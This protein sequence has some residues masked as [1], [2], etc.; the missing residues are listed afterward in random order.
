MTSVTIISS[1]GEGMPPRRSPRFKKPEEGEVQV[2]M[3]AV[4]GEPSRKRAHSPDFSFKESKKVEEVFLRKMP[5]RQRMLPARYREEEKQTPASAKK[6]V[7]KRLLPC[8]LPRGVNYTPFST[9][10]PDFRKE[11]A[12]FWAK[13]GPKI[14]PKR[15]DTQERKIQLSLSRIIRDGDDSYF[16]SKVRVNKINEKVGY[17]VIARDRINAGTVVG[18]YGGEL[19]RFDDADEAD[20]NG[21]VFGFHDTPELEGWFIDGRHCTNFTAFMN[22]A[23]SD[24]VHCNVV[25]VIY[26]GEEGPYVAFITTKT[27]YPKDQ[28]LYDYGDNYWRLLGIFPDNL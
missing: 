15:P 16:S 25:P 17:G 18:I 7:Q 1:S 6:K 26:L 21:F 10:H 5:K 22:H 2:A 3:P 9:V 11:F 23:S 24:S 27:V 8:R 20:G 4:E 12:T 13:V 19:R 28:L 14:I